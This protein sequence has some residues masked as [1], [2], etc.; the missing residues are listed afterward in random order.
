MAKSAGRSHKPP[1][2]IQAVEVDLPIT[3]GQ[4]VKVA[5]LASTGGEAKM[6]VGGGDVR[7]NGEVEIRRG[8]KLAPGDIVAVGASAAKVEA[9]TTAADKAL[10]AGP[11][12]R[13]G[14]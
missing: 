8:H 12:S 11:L 5:G 9:R 7:V 4:F 13:P 3:V 6:L 1:G 10:P 14:S 2:K